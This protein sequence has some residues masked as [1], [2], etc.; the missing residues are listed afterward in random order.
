MT[1][2]RDVKLCNSNMDVSTGTCVH[3]CTHTEGESRHR[4]KTERQRQTD[5]QTDVHMRVAHTWPGSDILRMVDETFFV[6]IGC[7]L[8]PHL[9]DFISCKE[10]LGLVMELTW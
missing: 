6:I 3:A 4:V 9:E 10:F 2:Y 5:R 7:G 1:L 8:L